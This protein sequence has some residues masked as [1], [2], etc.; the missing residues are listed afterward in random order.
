[1]S[2]PRTIVRQTARVSGIQPF[3]II[4]PLFLGKSS[5]RRHCSSEADARRSP[6][7][8]TPSLVTRRRS[9]PFSGMA[10]CAWSRQGA[11]ICDSWR[12]KRPLPS[13]RIGKYGTSLA[14]TR[15][16]AP[17]SRPEQRLRRG[18]AVFPAAGR[19][20]SSAGGITRRHHP[21]CIGRH[22]HVMP[23]SSRKD[24]VLSCLWIAPL[25]KGP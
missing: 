2:G 10:P 25:T 19:G 1:M 15:S 11:Y 7:M 4:F 13:V 17:L 8:W 18:A 21:S 16:S 22:P 6:V 24:P 23:L 14:R 3:S 9:R 5:I 12:C 20:I